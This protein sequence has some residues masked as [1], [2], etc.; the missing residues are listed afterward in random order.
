MKTTSQL[1][2]FETESNYILCD[3]CK[4]PVY[5]KQVSTTVYAGFRD[6]KLN[7]FIGFKCCRTKFYEKYK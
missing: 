4:R 7:M 2:L 1:V 6:T 3:I 5:L